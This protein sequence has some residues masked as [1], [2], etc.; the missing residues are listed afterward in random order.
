[1][2]EYQVFSCPIDMLLGHSFDNMDFKA[3]LLR[4]IYAYG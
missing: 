4:G 3:E 1:M 2:S